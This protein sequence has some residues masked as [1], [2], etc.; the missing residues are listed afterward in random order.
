MTN[1]YNVRHSKV[2]STVLTTFLD[3]ANDAASSLNVFMALKM[4]T[5]KSQYDDTAREFHCIDG[6]RREGWLITG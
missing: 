1:R 2:Q 3:A 6:V 5:H 4:L